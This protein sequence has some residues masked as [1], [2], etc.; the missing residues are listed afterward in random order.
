MMRLIT[1]LVCTGIRV[2]DS[3]FIRGVCRA[4][5]GAIV[6]TSAN[7]S[8]GSSPTNVTDFQELWHLCAAVFDAGQLGD[9]RAGSTIIDLSQAGSF[10]I[11]RE[12]SEP[13]SV[14]HVLT[15][16]FTLSEQRA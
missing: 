9:D 15:R 6:L 11:V 12:G 7:I 16:N 14:R 8:G 3:D 13:D 4:H 5:G 1:L 2:P 10:R